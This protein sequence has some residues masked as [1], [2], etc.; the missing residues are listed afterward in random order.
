MSKQYVKLKIK[1]KYNYKRSV[2]G[3]NSYHINRWVRVWL[4]N[5]H[6]VLF[7]S[8]Y[9]HVSFLYIKVLAR[10]FS[11]KCLYQA[12]K[13]K[14]H[15]FVCWFCLFLQFSIWIMKLFRHLF[16]FHYIHEHLYVYIQ[17]HLMS[18]YNAI[19]QWLLSSDPAHIGVYYDSFNDTYVTLMEY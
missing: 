16:S 5:V 18:I 9:P 10:H 2:N 3:Y 19:I 6:H 8:W 15:V 11:L 14:V 1:K 12:R 7:Q 17:C 13:V 4:W